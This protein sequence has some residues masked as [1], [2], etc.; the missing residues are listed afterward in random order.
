[1]EKVVLSIK[2]TANI[3]NLGRTSVYHLIK[4]R[5]LDTIRLGRRRLV[6]IDSVHRLIEDLSD[7]Q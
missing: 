4:E 3:L 7:G 1:M 5:K 2:E 6:K